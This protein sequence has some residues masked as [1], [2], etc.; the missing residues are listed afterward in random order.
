MASTRLRAAGRRATRL[1]N[2]TAPVTLVGDETPGL[3]QVERCGRRRVFDADD[4]GPTFTAVV[5]VAKDLGVRL[6][7]ET[8]TVDGDD[9]T[10]VVTVVVSD[11]PHATGVPVPLLRRNGR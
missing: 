11:Q 8:A 10:A 9:A 7:I 4:L 3:D 6:E 1:A 2:R 5:K